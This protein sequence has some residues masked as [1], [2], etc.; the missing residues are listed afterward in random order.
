M[1]IQVIQHVPYEG[2]A[3]IA[4][5]AESRDHVVTI[6]HAT[7][8][9]F[10]APAEYDLLVVMGGPMNIY[11]VDLHPWLL[12]EK[13]AVAQAIDAGK[14]VLGVCLGAQLIADVLGGSVGR[15]DE[16]EIGWFP[17]ELSGAGSVSPV[18]GALPASF[19][20]G[21]WHWDTFSVPPG[22]VL[23]AS[24]E[25]CVNQA[26]EFDDG[27]VIGV[28]FHLEW[29]REALESLVEHGG[30]DLVVATWVQSEHV[31]LESERPFLESRELVHRLLDAL[32]GRIS[33]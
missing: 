29:T 19:M 25:A 3:G 13:E 2:P 28:Q 21:H 1:R 31:L 5:W 22:A 11:E 26:F 6:T 4:E 23:V 7:T 14:G 30:D 27:R 33:S 18:F 9:A 17:V 15:N 24:S 16:P 10:P 32:E 20:A 8:G 12:A